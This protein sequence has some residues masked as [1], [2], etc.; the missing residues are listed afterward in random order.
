MSLDISID[1]MKEIYA[2]ETMREAVIAVLEQCGPRRHWNAHGPIEQEAK[3]WMLRILKNEDGA[4]GVAEAIIGVW[5]AHHGMRS[6]MM[7]DL[8]SPG[9]ASAEEFAD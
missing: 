7:H 1:D 9:R 5:E 6:M 8:C 4:I 2:K 3:K